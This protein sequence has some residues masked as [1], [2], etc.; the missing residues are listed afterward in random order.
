MRETADPAVADPD[1]PAAPP[2][3]NGE[4]VFAEP[5]ESRAFGAAVAL[6]DGG[7]VEFEEF[8]ARLI[9]E[10]S[11]WGRAQGTNDDRYRYYELWLTALER[12]LLERELV[13]A[14]RLEAVLHEIEHEW[15]HDDSH[16][17]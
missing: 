13:D 2:R 6:H 8:R 5:W 15:E 1:A 10:I 9:E 7:V 4:L 14:E 16:G 12:T 17:A 3:A 11:S